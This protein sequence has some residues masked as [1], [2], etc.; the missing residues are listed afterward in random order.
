MWV[1]IDFL[2]LLHLVHVS[3]SC[4]RYFSRNAYFFSRASFKNEVIAKVLLQK[5]KRVRHVLL[6][7]C[8]TT[9]TSFDSQKE[10]MS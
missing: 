4:I 3:E 5:R 6:P 8:T 10:I 2:L 9:T 1:E 7:I